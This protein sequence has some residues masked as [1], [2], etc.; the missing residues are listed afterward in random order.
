M[1]LLLL[2]FSVAIH[3]TPSDIVWRAA[4]MPYPPGVQMVVLNGTPEGGQSTIRLRLP[5]GTKLTQ[6]ARSRDA[7]ITVLSGSVT[8]EKDVFPPGSFFVVNVFN[9]DITATEESIIQVTSDGPWMK[10]ELPQLP[11]GESLVPTRSDDAE[12]S[13]IDATPPSNNE[14][15]AE[16]TIK[17]RVK[18]S[19]K[20]FKPG[21][22]S[23]SSMFESTRPG[24]TVS[25]PVKVPAGSPPP[26]RPNILTAEKGEMTLDVA[27][28]D[29]LARDNVARPLHMWIYLLHRTGEHS[30]RPVVRTPT[31]V[32][33]VK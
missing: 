7:G 22:Y 15:T 30:S 27:V 29:L 4:P 14:V 1:N 21:D 32:Y 26:L 19:V 6:A 20:N 24:V 9:G 33:N 18:Y 13:I 11:S 31:L 25:A 8:V 17:V 2:L 23:L 16:S 28:R 5:A 12:V 10:G 3:V